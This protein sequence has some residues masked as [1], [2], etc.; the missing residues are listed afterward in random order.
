LAFLQV[1]FSGR[2]FNNS[3][4]VLAGG[5]ALL[6]GACEPEKARQQ[7]A[8]RRQVTHELRQH[9]YVT[10][11]PLARQLLQRTPRDERVRKQLVHALIGLHD[12]DG[13]KESLSEWRKA[14]ASPSPRADEFEGDIAREEHDF[15]AAYSAWQKVMQGQ[16]NNRRVRQKIALLQQ[17]QQHWAEADATWSTALQIKETTTARIN[18]ALCR[19]HLHQWNEAFDDLHRA[20]QL[21]PDDPEVRRWSKLFEGL[22]KYL[23]QIREIDAKLS[24]LPEEVGLLGDRALLFLRGGDAEL[25]LDDAERADKLAPWAIRPRLFR[26]IALILLSRGKE[27]EALSVRRP[28][29]LD[30]L[31]PELLESVSRLDQAISVERTNPEHFIARSWQLNEMAQP[32]L[33]LQ[34]AETAVRLDSRSAEAL[35]EL[36]YSLSKL[37]RLEEAFTKIK[38][39]TDF[40]PNS[41]TAWQYRGELEMAQGNHLAA[42]DSLSRALGIH[43]GIA[44]LQKREECYRRLG[45]FARAEE[46]HRAVQ[47]LMA[48]TLQ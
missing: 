22:D 24:I 30:T 14:V 39:A 32:K 8:L 27:C 15:P 40:E 3:C 11:A 38:Q 37:G 17:S 16:P 13:A 21:G 31:P 43:Q 6:F 1:S 10:A 33:A 19:R 26:A 5:I 23:D 36:S 44:A 29:S 45:L 7:K 41:A 25:A 34:D 35:T 18:R 12:L 9:S 20:Q 4:L 2:R 47:K 42:V 46:D 28:L 48:T